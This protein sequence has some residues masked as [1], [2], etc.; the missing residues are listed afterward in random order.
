MKKHTN[1]I[2]VNILRDEYADY[3][4]NW[5]HYNREYEMLLKA[6]PNK[7]RSEIIQHYKNFFALGNTELG[8]D[9]RIDIDWAESLINDTASNNNSIIYELK[10]WTSKYEI[11]FQFWGPNNNNVHLMKDD[12]SLLE[13]GSFD[14]PEECIKIA[15]Q[16]IYRINRVPKEERLF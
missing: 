9:D 13:T 7:Y 14:T 8:E 2:A 6:I 1:Q 10:K 16:Y 4:T 5:W 3:D 12:V 11:T 15:L